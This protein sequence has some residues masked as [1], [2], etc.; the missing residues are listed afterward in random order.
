[1]ARRSE[2]KSHTEQDVVDICEFQNT[3]GFRFTMYVCNYTIFDVT[4]NKRT[5]SIHTSLFIVPKQIN[6]I[7]KLSVTCFMELN[8]CG[9]I[10]SKVRW[11]LQIT[12]GDFFPLYRQKIIISLHCHDWCMKKTKDFLVHNWS[13]LERQCLSVSYNERYSCKVHVF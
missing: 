10:S 3:F 2:F 13:Q 6:K 11:K 9:H 5:D 4:L 7:Y 8:N 1:M 12:I